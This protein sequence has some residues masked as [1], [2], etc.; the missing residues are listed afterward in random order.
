M[1]L[2][3][4]KVITACFPEVNM[5]WPRRPSYPTTILNPRIRYLALLVCEKFSKSSTS[6]KLIGAVSKH[7]KKAFVSPDEPILCV[8]F[9]VSYRSLLHSSRHRIECQPLLSWL[10]ES[11]CKQYCPEQQHR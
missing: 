7:L 2:N 3:P 4:D 6:N 5:I 11:I 9:A 8:H 10:Q 1:H